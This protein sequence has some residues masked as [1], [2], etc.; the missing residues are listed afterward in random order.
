MLERRYEFSSAEKTSSNSAESD[1]A[2]SDPPKMHE[3]SIAHDLIELALEQAHLHGSSKIL[4]VGVRIG[5]LSS[6]VPEALEFAFPEAAQDTLAQGALLEI[7]LLEAVGIC[8]EHGNVVLELHKGIRCPCCDKPI[9]EL[10]QGEELEL[11][12]L[13]LG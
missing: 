13:E 3:A 4:K 9:L 1:S 11:D 8:S 7:V 6:V 5:R 12:T 2:E 10:I